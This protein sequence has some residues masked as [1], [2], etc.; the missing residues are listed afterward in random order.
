M[1]VRPDET[2]AAFAGPPRNLPSSANDELDEVVAGAGLLEQRAEQHE[3]EDEVGRDAER[4]AEH[5]F[6]GEPEVRGRARQRGAAMRQQAGQIRTE[7]D[8]EQRDDGDDRHPRAFGAARGFEQQHHA[9]DG[10]ENVA[11]R[12]QARTHGDVAIEHDQIQHRT[13]AGGGQQPVDKRHA[14]ARRRHEG[15]VRRERQEQREAQVKRA[16]LGVAE[17]AEAQDVGQ[18]R[19]VPELEQ[20]P[21]DGDRIDQPSG[22]AARLA[23]AGIGFGDKLL[24][25]DIRR[26]RVRHP[27]SPVKNQRRGTPSRP[28]PY[29]T[30][31]ILKRCARPLT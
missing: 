28:A 16:R 15:R 8:I 17:D 14:V 12:R 1:P 22:T 30:R 5:A 10:G 31:I 7:E 26:H 18:R 11:L 19:G 23:P 4:D 3:Q 9:D 25:V 2:T 24:Q 6:G 21:G 13:N 27:S 29:N 20:R